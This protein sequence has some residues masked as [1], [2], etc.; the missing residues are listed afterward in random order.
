MSASKESTKYSEAR[1]AFDD[2]PLNERAAFLVE[3]AAETIARGIEHLSRTVANEM[4]TATEHEAPDEPGAGRGAAHEGVR[5]EQK[6]E[7]EDD[8]RTDA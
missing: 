2:L 4:R 6:S 7:N 3:S 1:R 5:T 8:P